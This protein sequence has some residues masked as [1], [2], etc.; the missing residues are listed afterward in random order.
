[1]VRSGREGIDEIFYAILRAYRTS[2]RCNDSSQDEDMRCKTLPQI[3][4]HE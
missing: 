4:Q 2:N 1:M 3:A